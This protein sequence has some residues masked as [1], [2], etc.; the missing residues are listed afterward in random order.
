MLEA[1]RELVN[2]RP[3]DHSNHL[4]DTE[5]ASTLK[6]LD[7]HFHAVVDIR[8]PSLRPLTFCFPSGQDSEVLCAVVETLLHLLKSPVE[9]LCFL[10]FALPLQP[11]ICT[12]CLAG[13]CRFS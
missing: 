8:V 13:E 1:F 7:I 2:Q 10:D 9:F 4:G 3:E 6:R 12:A 11:I 5:D